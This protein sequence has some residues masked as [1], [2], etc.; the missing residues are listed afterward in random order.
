MI[1]LLYD[2]APIVVSCTISLASVVVA[3][4]LFNYDDGVNNSCKI[5]FNR[6][7]SRLDGIK[8]ELMPI[9]NKTVDSIKTLDNNHSKIEKVIKSLGQEL[10]FKREYD[11]HNQVLIDDIDTELFMCRRAQVCVSESKQVIADLWE[12]VDA[13]DAAIKNSDLTINFFEIAS[14]CTYPTAFLITLATSLLYTIYHLREPLYILPWSVLSWSMYRIS[15]LF[16]VCTWFSTKPP[17]INK[18]IHKIESR[19]ETFLKHARR[20]DV[21]SAVASI[22]LNDK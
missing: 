14:L 22:Y 17:Y 9:Y 2:Y 3:N 16:N 12:S 11:A 1:D 21:I 15:F 20:I 4:Y 8:D 18:H 5:K 10:E 13:S 19:K 6:L 7:Q